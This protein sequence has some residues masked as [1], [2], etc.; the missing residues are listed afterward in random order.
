MENSVSARALCPF[1]LRTVQAAGGGGK[2]QARS[3]GGFLCRA[4][5]QGA[6]RGK[7]YDENGVKR[8]K[9]THKVFTFVRRA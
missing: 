5:G 6:G 7:I 2:S 1:I 3:G 9:K 4:E 8:L